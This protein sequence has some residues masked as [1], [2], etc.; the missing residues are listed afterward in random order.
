M[1]KNQRFLLKAAFFVALF[2]IG[3][4]FHDAILGVPK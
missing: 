1:S 4:I 2:V 3:V